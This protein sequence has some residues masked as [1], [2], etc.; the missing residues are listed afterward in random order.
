[1][2]G[3]FKRTPTPKSQSAARADATRPR[4]PGARLLPPE[5]APVPQVVEGNRESDWSLWEDSV[6]FQ[7]S[8]MS[9]FGP[10]TLPLGLP[11][12]KPENEADYVD[13]FDSVRKKK[14]R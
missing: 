5:P 2:F 8:Q 6:S 10:T 7:D 13:P 4:L 14:T 9:S 11:E 1:M 12:E 3:F